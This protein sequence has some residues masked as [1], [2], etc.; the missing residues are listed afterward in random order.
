MNEGVYDGMYVIVGN[1]RAADNG[2]AERAGMCDAVY[3][4]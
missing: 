4:V 1:G 3:D 2:Q